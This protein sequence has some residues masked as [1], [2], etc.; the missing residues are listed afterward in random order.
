MRRWRT[1]ALLVPAGAV[2]FTAFAVPLVRL[3][4]I[5]LVESRPS[6]ALSDTVT[7][8]NYVAFATD[9][10]YLQLLAHSVLLATVVTTATLLCAFPLA[11]FLARVGL[12][13]RPFFYALTVAPLLVSSVVRTYGWMALLGD[14]GPVNDV[15]LAAGLVRAPVRL[16]NSYVGVAIGLVEILMPYMT[17]ALV[18]GFGRLDPAYEEA[19]ASLG[20]GPWT[21]LRRVVLPLAWPG[22][23]LGCLLCF[24]LAMSSFITPKLLGGGRVFLLATE[25]YDQAMVRLQ[26]PMAATISVVVLAVF[27]TL[28]TAYAKI[29]RRF[30][31]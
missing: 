10:Y 12:R 25:I 20:A 4:R 6:G 27:G 16:V 11:L 24:V 14:Q 3:G 29:V 5:S 19:A 18:A 15:L 28:S 8:A 30:D 26:W 23:T 31:T 21:R 7:A 17:L 9:S 13:W 22:I 1:L 2:T